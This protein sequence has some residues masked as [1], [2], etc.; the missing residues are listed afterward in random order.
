MPT[1]ISHYL[2]DLGLEE[3][4]RLDSQWKEFQSGYQDEI[5]TEDIVCLKDGRYL[6]MTV[7]WTKKYFPINSLTPWIKI[8]TPITQE[9]Y[10][11]I[12]EENGGILDT[13]ELRQAI[14]KRIELEKALRELDP[15]CPKCGYPMTQRSGPR[16]DFWGCT[17]YPK[18][19][20]TMNWDKKLAAQRKAIYQELEQYQNL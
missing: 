17:R 10:E 8:E 13:P 1:A 4:V 16:G 14:N 3:I 15:I 12:R 6:Q 19:N 5:T 7:V 9:E 20:G 18:C 11:K 2:R